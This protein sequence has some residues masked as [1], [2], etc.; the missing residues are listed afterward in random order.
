MANQRVEA[1]NALVSPGRN[2]GRVLEEAFSVLQLDDAL[3][4]VISRIDEMRIGSSEQHHRGNVDAVQLRPAGMGGRD[5][6]L[7]DLRVTAKLGERRRIRLPAFWVPPRAMNVDQTAR[8]LHVDQVQAVRSEQRNI[9]FESLALT[10]DLK[11]VQQGKTVG[12]VIPQMR[13]R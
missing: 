1:A 12:Q 9:D 13:N 4:V 3:R 7:D 8:P 11:V 2:A 6:P 10:L 5:Q